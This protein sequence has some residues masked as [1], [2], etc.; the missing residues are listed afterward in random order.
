MTL[1]GTD[2]LTSLLT[3]FLDVQ[4]RRAE[5]VS[6]NIANAETP[7]YRAKELDFASYLRQAAAEATEPSGEGVQANQFSDEPRIFERELPEITRL[8]GNTV[9]VGR[10]M[11]TLAET[12][13]QYLAGTQLL[14]SRL[15]TLRAAIREG[16]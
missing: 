15:R 14:Q 8:D 5:V 1:P 2:R 13:M 11:S 9:E 16:R 10:E 7:G 4:S 3:T 12:G 6:S